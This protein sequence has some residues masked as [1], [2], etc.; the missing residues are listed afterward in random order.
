MH[1]LSICMA[2]MDQLEA[3]ARERNAEAIVRVELEVGVLSGVESDLLENAW[4]IASTGTIAEKAELRIETAELIVECSSC[5]ARTSAKPNYLR[6]GDCG[7]NQ[8]KVIA[9]EE[10]TL[11]RVELDTPAAEAPET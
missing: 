7:S 1:E 5:G 6:C 11:L 2:L 8:T 3:I 4:P 9:G 10:L